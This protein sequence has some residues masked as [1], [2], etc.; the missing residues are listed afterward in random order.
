MTLRRLYKTYLPQIKVV[1]VV[2][3]RELLIMMKCQTTMTTETVCGRFAIA[4]NRV[5]TRQGCT[6]VALQLIISLV[7]SS[8]KRKTVGI[9]MGQ[10]GCDG[11]R[12]RRNT[13]DIHQLP[14]NPLGRGINV[15]EKSRCFHVIRLLIYQ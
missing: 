1:P 6:L 8:D 4:V 14:L 10:F 11:K 5:V 15:S 13:S 3:L 12:K 9:R 7:T 2:L